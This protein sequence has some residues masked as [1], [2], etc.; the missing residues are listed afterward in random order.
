MPY[1]STN[2]T[3]DI[4]RCLVSIGAIEEYSMPESN[5]AV[6]ADVAVEAI[7]SM[8]GSLLAARLMTE[9]AE[10]IGSLDTFADQYGRVGML[11]LCRLQ[12]AIA[13]D[14][15]IQFRPREKNLAAFI[16]ALPSASEWRKHVRV[17][18]RESN[19]SVR[20]IASSLIDKLTRS[21]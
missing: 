4:L 20:S 13:K 16:L 18:S 8:Y 9:V 12:E 10:A 11:A 19:C 6:Q 2:F 3:D 17:V 5:L 7:I 15:V 21:R 14:R 1:S